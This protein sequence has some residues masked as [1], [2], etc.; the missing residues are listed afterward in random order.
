MGISG[1]FSSTGWASQVGTSEKPFKYVLQVSN[2]MFWQHLDLLEHALVQEILRNIKKVAFFG[3]F[4]TLFK[5][6]LGQSG[7]HLGRTF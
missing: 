5:Y 1:L 4:R 2:F 7:G 6:L 3:N